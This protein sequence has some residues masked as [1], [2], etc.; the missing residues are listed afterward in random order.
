MFIPPVLVLFLIELVYQPYF[1]SISIK[2][3]IVRIILICIPV[4]VWRKY[5]FA[6]ARKDFNWTSWKFVCGGMYFEILGFWNGLTRV[7]VIIND[8]GE[9]F[10]ASLPG[11]GLAYHYVPPLFF[12]INSVL[13]SVVVQHKVYGSLVLKFLSLAGLVL[14]D[15]SHAKTHIILSIFFWK[16]LS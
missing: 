9:V 2:I 15:A 3:N 7:G 12:A 14:Y 13:T 4:M 16:S 10:L 11:T 1:T 6:Y 8:T 5:L